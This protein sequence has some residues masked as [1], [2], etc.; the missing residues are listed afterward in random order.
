VVDIIPAYQ[1]STTLNMVLKKKPMLV[2]IASFLISRGIGVAV[3]SRRGG[4]R[5]V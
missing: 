5:G 3:K 4:I 2:G 1:V